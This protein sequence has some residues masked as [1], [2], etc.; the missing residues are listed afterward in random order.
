[1]MKWYALSFIGKLQK[2]QIG[3]EATTLSSII[4]DWHVKFSRSF[5]LK[6]FPLFVPTWDWELYPRNY[7]A[8]LVM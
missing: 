7:R 2:D 3:I 8:C 1:M 4:F 6:I 5:V